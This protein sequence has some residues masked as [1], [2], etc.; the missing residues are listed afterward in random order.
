MAFERNEHVEE[1]NRDRETERHADKE[2]E[3]RINVETERQRKNR[4]QTQGS[5]QRDRDR[6]TKMEKVTKR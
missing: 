6:N 2:T 4:K 5:I 3:R 1:R